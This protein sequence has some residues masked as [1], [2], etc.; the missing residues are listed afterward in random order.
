VVAGEFTSKPSAK[1]ESL[2]ELHR[3]LKKLKHNV[4]SDLH[5]TIAEFE[6]RIAEEFDRLEAVAKQRFTEWQKRTRAKIVQPAAD[7][8]ARVMDKYFAGT[9]PFG[10]IKARTDIPDAFIV[11]TILGLASQGE[12]LCAF[13][14][15]AQQ[16]PSLRNECV[17]VRGVSPHCGGSGAGE[18]SID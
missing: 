11:E 1:I 15:A 3:T 17:G 12:L 14:K 7:R 4:P 13:G 2:E 5:V 6:T 10:S 18:Y 9:L 8:A 16:K